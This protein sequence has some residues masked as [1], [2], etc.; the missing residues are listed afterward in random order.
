[1]FDYALGYMRRDKERPAPTAEAL[2]R[3]LADRHQPP[4][5]CLRADTQLFRKLGNFYVRS[6][7]HC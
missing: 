3:N 6:F 4:D 1:L 2:Q 7:A 5:D